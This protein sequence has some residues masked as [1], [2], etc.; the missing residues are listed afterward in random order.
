MN[1]R[2][3]GKEIDEV[4]SRIDIGHTPAEIA[5]GN[6][7]IAEAVK[8]RKNGQKPRGTRRRRERERHDPLDEAGL[9][10]VGNADR[11]IYLH[12]DNL[13]F[14]DPWDAWLVWDGKRWLRDRERIVYRWAEE[15]ATAI[16]GEA[17]EEPDPERKT[18]LA[19]HAI[20]S[21]TESR[22]K[23]MVGLA[24]SK[25]D[26]PVL[27]ETFDRAP[28]LLNCQNGTL[29]LRTGELREHRREDLLS[30]ITPVA[31]DHSAECP[32]WLQFLDEVT[33]GNE[34]LK[35]FLQ[36]LAGYCL[37]GDVSEQ[38][39]FFLH[40]PGANG[41]SK[42]LEALLY[43]LGDY[44]RT[45][46]PDLLMMRMGNDHPTAIAD[47]CGAR[48]VTTVETD[49]GR[50]FAESFVKQLV[51]GDVLKA[52]RMREDF[53]E[54]EPECKVLLAA[55]HKPTIR[56]TDWAIWRR[57]DLIPFSVVIPEERRDKALG[58]KL[59]GEASG[60][61][62]W[63]VEGCVTWQRDGLAEPNEVRAATAAYRA[64]SDVLGDF[65]ADC[66]LQGATFQVSRA[67]LRKAYE[68][69]AQR[70]GER[71][72]GAKMMADRLRE[73]GFAEG[74]VSQERGWLGVGLQ[75][76]AVG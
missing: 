9:T 49:E 3:S 12:A 73:R 72:I 32:R 29:S 69:W 25:P 53:W 51:G 67:A 6:V 30:K 76:E 55:N 42:F 34:R 47:L 41:K 22:I 45:M 15:T 75:D 18:A 24:R 8:G 62:R 20:R 61:L 56:G 7:L 10:D 54:F 71:P 26:V 11:L 46:A 16:F 4:N 14:C 74:K 43:V 65:I 60:I 68:D 17:A 44:G 52:R 70:A 27:P 59:K 40:G 21:Q 64:E 2:M 31:Y 58:A 36:R 5:E 63:A 35:A 66:C 50:R 37:T 33:N 39:L 38:K 13:R 1:G 28:W 48:L 57:I 19:K 23:A